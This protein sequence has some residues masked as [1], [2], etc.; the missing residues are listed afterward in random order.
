[1]NDDV[2][3]LWCCM[4]YDIV[5]WVAEQSGSQWSDDWA[6]IW[7]I[8]IDC[9]KLSFKNKNSTQKKKKM[10]IYAFLINSD[11]M[12]VLIIYC[13]RLFVFISMHLRC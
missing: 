7:L 2:M 4:L 11:F 13:A 5:H 3:E 9:T 10:C 6:K 1:M 12:F 8:A